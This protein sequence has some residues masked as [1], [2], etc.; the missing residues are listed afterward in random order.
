MTRTYIAMSVRR[1]AIARIRCCNTIEGDRGRGHSRDLLD[2]SYRLD[3]I[4]RF[5]KGSLR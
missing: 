3:G 4:G 1:I 2:L 5:V